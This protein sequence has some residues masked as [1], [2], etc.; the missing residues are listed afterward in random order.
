MVHCGE[1]G[2]NIFVNGQKVGSTFD[3]MHDQV[4]KVYPDIGAFVL[5][6]SYVTISELSWTTSKPKTRLFFE[7]PLKKL[8]PK[9]LLS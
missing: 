9:K 8:R 1:D 5:T 3:C 6:T 7:L 2:F 4:N